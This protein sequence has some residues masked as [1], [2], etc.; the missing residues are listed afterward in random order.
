MS[1]RKKNKGQKKIKEIKGAQGFAKL[2][3]KNVNELSRSKEF[4]A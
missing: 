1:E 3:V 2:A 4:T